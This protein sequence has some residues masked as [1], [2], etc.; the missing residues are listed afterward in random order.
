MKTMKTRFRQTETNYNSKEKSEVCIRMQH[1]QQK[2]NAE[3]YICNYKVH[4]YVI[5]EK[6]LNA[7][8]SC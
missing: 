1:S 3:T 4:Y 7:T 2:G 6:R 5:K 8:V